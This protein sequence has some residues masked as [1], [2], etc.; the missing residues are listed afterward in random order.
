[1]FSESGSIPA[2]QTSFGC[3]IEDIAP[4][5]ELN[6]VINTFIRAKTF[7]RCGNARAEELLLERLGLFEDLDTLEALESVYIDFVNMQQKKR[8]LKARASGNR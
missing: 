7:G 8:D 2:C 5:V 3:K 1:M 4:D 6:R